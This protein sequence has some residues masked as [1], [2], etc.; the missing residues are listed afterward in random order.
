MKNF[1][2]FVD[3]IITTFNR[4]GFLEESIESVENQTYGN[5]NIIIVDDGSEKQIKLFPSLKKRK[6]NIY[7]I[8]QNNSGI[9]SARNTGIKLSKSKYIAFLDDDDLWVKN[10]VEKQMNILLNT[11]YSVCYT[12]EKWMRNGKHLNQHKKHQKYSGDIFDK[13]LSLCIISPS[14]ILLE[15]KV[16]D[17]IGM[18]DTDFEVCEDYELWL[19]LALKYKIYF[20]DEPLIIKQGGHNDQLS[21]KLP[22]MDSFR[23]DALKKLLD[24]YN[25]SM[26]SYKIKIVIAELEKKSRIIINGCIKRGLN[27]EI[28]KYERIIKSCKAKYGLL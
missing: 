22:V 4:P 5:I 25:S 11:E 16:F 13:V 10:K 17:T 9:S 15:K 7:Y 19:R 14:S 6:K 26:D 3:V 2:P 27:D 1:E 18:F 23:I 20:L 21:R 28:E 12:N 8:Y 24:N